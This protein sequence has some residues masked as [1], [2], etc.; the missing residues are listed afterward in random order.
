ML[1]QFEVDNS[2]NEL[3]PGEYGSVTF[4]FPANEKSLQIPAGAIMYK[5]EGP[6]IAVVAGDRRVKFK[7]VEILRDL[8]TSLNIAALLNANELVINNPPESLME[9]DMVKLKTTPSA[10]QKT[11]APSII[12]NAASK[13]KSQP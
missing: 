3:L 1:M 4:I 5:K 12:P 8:G 13:T 9:G 7:R 6:F 2:S 10:E 11:T